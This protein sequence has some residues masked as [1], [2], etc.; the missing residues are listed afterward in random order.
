MRVGREMWALE[1]SL[2]VDYSSH[3]WGLLDPLV[4]RRIRR[5]EKNTL[6]VACNR[7]PLRIINILPVAMAPYKIP[8]NSKP[9]VSICARINPTKIAI[10]ATPTSLAFTNASKVQGAL[11]FTKWSPLNCPKAIPVSNGFPIQ[12]LRGTKKNKDPRIW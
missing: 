11:K 6:P 10:R 5:P 8:T 2:E 1:D 9:L 4:N 12:M 3:S 7:L